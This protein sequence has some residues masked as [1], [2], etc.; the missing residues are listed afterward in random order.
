M[1]LGKSSH[2]VLLKVLESRCVTMVSIYMHQCVSN[3]VRSL[4]PIVLPG[5]LE[6]ASRNLHE[7][8]QL[9]APTRL[10]LAYEESKQRIKKSAPTYLVE[11][12]LQIGGDMT[13]H[14]SD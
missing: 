3:A 9:V 5:A 13:W 14:K 10:V 11:V 12:P 7:G 2:K 8:Q 6:R 4:L 1:K